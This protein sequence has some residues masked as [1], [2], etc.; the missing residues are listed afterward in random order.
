VFYVFDFPNQVLLGDVIERRIN[1]YAPLIQEIKVRVFELSIKCHF[2]T[3]AHINTSNN[4]GV[5]EGIHPSR[6]EESS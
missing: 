4:T 1:T 2:H 6:K 5:A 3:D